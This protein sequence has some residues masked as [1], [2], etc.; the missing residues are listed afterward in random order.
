MYM[1]NNTQIKFESLER[2]LHMIQNSRKNHKIFNQKII[3]VL[4]ET[5][6]INM[7]TLRLHLLPQFKMIKKRYCLK[8]QNAKVSY[9]VLISSRG[10]SASS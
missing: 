10:L 1:T 5:L 4:S 6:K 3:V 2:T 9:P 8:L 7:H